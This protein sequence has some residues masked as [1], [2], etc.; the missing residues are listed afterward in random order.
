MSDALNLK[1]GSICLGK[2]THISPKSV[3]LLL[4]SADDVPLTQKFEGVI[5]I[6]NVL[7]HS[8]DSVDI[9]T[10]FGLGDVVRCRIKSLNESF[11]ILLRCDDRDLGVVLARGEEHERM[12]GVNRLQ[13]KGVQT[14]A[15]RRRKV[16]L[17]S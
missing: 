8:L 15:L 16:A 7:P 6:E 9:E 1:I 11:K 13:V 3:S 10:L 2:V 4:L 14:G 5:N 17:L 12:L